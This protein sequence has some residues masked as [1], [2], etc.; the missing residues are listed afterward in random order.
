MLSYTWTGKVKLKGNFLPRPE[1][2]KSPIRYFTYETFNCRVIKTKQ[3]YDKG[4]LGLEKSKMNKNT[5]KSKVDV[6]QR[7]ADG[8]NSYYFL[9][10]P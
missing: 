5:Q 7:N 1:V 4:R 10:R 2:V 6:T 8:L 9:L 3:I